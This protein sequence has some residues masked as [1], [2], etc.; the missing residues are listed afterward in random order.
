MLPT[1]A[2]AQQISN[3]SFA[4]RLHIIQKDYHMVLSWHSRAGI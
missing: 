1:A 4:S 3:A 2:S